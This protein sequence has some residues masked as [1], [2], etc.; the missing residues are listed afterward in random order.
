MVREIYISDQ[1]GDKV[2]EKI[3][4]HVTY[5]AKGYASWGSMVDREGNL[6]SDP[7]DPILYE[8]AREQ[9]IIGTP[10]E[11]IQKITEYKE[12]LSIGNLICRCK[13][14]GLSH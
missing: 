10:E 14:P 7:E 12:K 8:I 6:L 1:T 11:C 3:K 4:E 5:T 9:S 13:F 2:W